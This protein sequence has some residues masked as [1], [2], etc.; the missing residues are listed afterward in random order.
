MHCH[1]FHLPFL[2]ACIHYSYVLITVDIEESK[3]KSL[4]CFGRIWIFFLSFCPITSFYPLNDIRRQTDNLMFVFWLLKI[5]IHIVAFM[6]C[7][8]ISIR[9]VSR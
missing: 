1:N 9:K 6:Q 7:K 5:S 8:Y 4:V 2:R 3:S